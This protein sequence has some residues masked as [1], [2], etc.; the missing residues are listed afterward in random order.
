MTNEQKVVN[1]IIANSPKTRPTS[2]YK[3]KE[4]LADS[5]LTVDQFLEVIMDL[6]DQQLI[7]NIF[8]NNSLTAISLTIRF[9]TKLSSH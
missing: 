7:Q 1:A 2:T 9:P 4:I 6:A 5:G 3:I 8:G